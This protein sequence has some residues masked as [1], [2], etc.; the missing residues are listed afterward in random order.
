MQTF[1]PC[2]IRYLRKDNDFINEH[3]QQEFGLFVHANGD[4]AKADPVGMGA[5]KWELGEKAF[6]I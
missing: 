5:D 3:S 2:F 6:L 1:L 4:F